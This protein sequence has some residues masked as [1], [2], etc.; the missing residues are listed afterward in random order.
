[1]ATLSYS[2]LVHGLACCFLIGLFLAGVCIAGWRRGR[3]VADCLLELAT[4]VALGIIAGSSIVVVLGLLGALSAVAAW[5][6]L[7]GLILGGCWRLLRN[8]P[9]LP[10]S[11]RCALSERWK[12]LP[13]LMKLTAAF[14]AFLPGALAVNILIGALAPDVQR[15]SLWYH[16]TLPVQWLLRGDVA[17]LTYTMPS[18]YTLLVEALY[19]LLLPLDDTLFI[20]AFIAQIHLLTIAVFLAIGWRFG[21]G[22]GLLLTAAIAPFAYASSFAYAPIPSKPDP[23]TVF[24]LGVGWWRFAAML[25]HVEEPRA[26]EVFLA[27]VIC[28]GAVMAKLSSLLLLMP[29]GLCFLVVIGQ[30][31]RSPVRFMRIVAAATLGG[32]LVAAPWLIRAAIYSGNPVIHVARGILPVSEEFLPALRGYDVVPMFHPLTADGIRM[33]LTESL[34]MRLLVASASLNILFFIIPVASAVSLASRMKSVRMTGLGFLLAYLIWVPLLYGKGEELR[35]FGVGALAAAP[36]LA[37]FGAEISRRVR[38]ELLP[39][40][41]LAFVIATGGSYAR[42]QITFATI[43]TVN[44]PFRPVVTTHDRLQWLKPTA[45]GLR[46]HYY[47]EV[48][49]ALPRDAHVLLP[50]SRGPFYLNRKAE[51]CDYFTCPMLDDWWRGMDHIQAHADLQARGITHILTES[52][53]LDPRIDAMAADNLIVRLP[54]ESIPD[55][56]ALWL[57]ATD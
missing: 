45:D 38:R 40:L 16:L 34:P 49:R 26:R 19:T 10:A 4:R 12:E 23:V 25:D 56:W 8:A 39:I 27:G 5:V 22:G 48:G 52:K 18:T 32:L 7:A 55:D 44:W 46:S 53:T 36:A 3:G 15:D 41:S 33:A 43:P 17:M 2:L 6:L 29:L 30:R 50:D 9:T 42:Q 21:G 14:T 20:T 54:M 11:Q 28:S 57:A 13:A 37:G 1:M 31:L 47:R 51:W 24:L 35:Y